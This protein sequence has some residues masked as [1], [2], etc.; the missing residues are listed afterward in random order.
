MNL[1]WLVVRKQ[2]GSDFREESRALLGSRSLG[3]VAGDVHR[4]HEPTLLIEARGRAHQEV[5]AQ[6]RLMY[7]GRVL[8]TVPAGL[9]VRA[10]LGWLRRSVDGHEIG[11]GVESP[12]PVCGAGVAAPD[13]SGPV[14]WSAPRRALLTPCSA[15]PVRDS[16]RPVRLA[17][18]GSS[19]RPRPVA[20]VRMLFS[21]D[22][23]SDHN[24]RRIVFVFG[25]RPQ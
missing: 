12:F 25:L 7:L 14:P 15:P 6:A 22:S 19:L 23:V 5:S 17:A 24:H 16:Y 2:Q 8:A 4:A 10:E 21:W 18:H 3:D 20:P 1:L 9:R 13:C 11:D